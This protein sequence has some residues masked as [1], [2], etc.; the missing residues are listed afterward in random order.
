MTKIENVVNESCS[1]DLL[2][3]KKS[4][5]GRLSLFLTSKIDSEVW[6]CPIFV[7]SPLHLFT[8]YQNFLWGCW[9]LYKTVTYFGYPS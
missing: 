7:G 2:F 9:I 1:P 8:K 6:K 5:S 4:V 3:L